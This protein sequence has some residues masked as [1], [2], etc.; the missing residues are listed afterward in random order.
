[1]SRIVQR[2]QSEKKNGGCD[3]VGSVSTCSRTDVIYALRLEVLPLPEHA[4]RELAILA[5]HPLSLRIAFLFARE[6][7]KRTQTG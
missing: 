5:E 7:A 1:M 3:K 6:E 2:S 4:N